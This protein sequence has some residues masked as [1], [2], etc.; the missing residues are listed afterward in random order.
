M[1]VKLATLYLCYQSVLEPLT[2]TQV[3][4]YLE[5]LARI[6]YR[7]VLLTFEPRPLTRTETRGWRDRLARQGISW[8]WIRYHKRPTVPA[9][10]WDVLSG[11]LYG[12]FL[13][14]R[15]NVR[16][17]HARSHVP[18]LMA[19]LLKRV[20]GTRMLFDLRGFLAEEYVDAG[21]WPSGGWLFRATKRAE[22]ALVRAA[23]GIVVLTTKAEDLLCQWYPKAMEG[24]PIQVIPCCVDLRRMD[25][26]T[27]KPKRPQR[28]EGEAIFIYA[29]KMGG[30]YRAD[31]MAA[32]VAVAKERI[33]RLCWRVLTQSDPDPFH[34]ILAAQGLES[35]VSIGRVPANEVPSILARAD[36]GLSFPAPSLSKLAMSPTKVGEYLAA[37]LP[38][39]STA[40]I[41][42][43]DALLAGSDK[44]NRRPVGVLVRDFDEKSYR[45]AL[46]G[47]MVL[48]NDPDTPERCRAVARDYL[49]LEQVGW[50]RYR[51]VYERLIGP[52]VQLRLDEANHPGSG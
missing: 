10:A 32:F 37:G 19:L 42:D 50:R 52:P 24:K 5:G 20:T 15:Y 8:H 27:P 11:C 2:Q 12:L 46:N 23:D 34:R 48:L 45:E 25:E 35:Q 31:S 43:V 33:P 14:R 40:G 38:V 47:L 26:H 21:V 16:L 36:V 9:T 39:V 30:A 51:E 29:G 49:D 41:G 7:V 17:L 18:G 13:I 44:N 4:A 6:G 3:I 1:N 28:R 22:R